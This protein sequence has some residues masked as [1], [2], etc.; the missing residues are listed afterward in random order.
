[1]RPAPFPPFAADAAALYAGMDIPFAPWPAVPM[2]GWYGQQTAV[3]SQQ[4]TLFSC[5]SA[6]L[7][8]G[9]NSLVA[10]LG[11]PL[12]LDVSMFAP[13]VACI[14]SIDA[15][16]LASSSVDL[17]RHRVVSL[18]GVHLVAAVVLDDAAPIGGVN[19]AAAAAIGVP[20][21][22][23]SQSGVGAPQ[24]EV[25]ASLPG[26]VDLQVWLPTS[27]GMVRLCVPRP[28]DLVNS[29][30]P[31]ADL[32]CAVEPQAPAS[33]SETVT[34]FGRYHCF[35][36]SSPLGFDSFVDSDAGAA[37]LLSDPTPY[38]CQLTFRSEW[39]SNPIGVQ[40]LGD[41]NPELRAV[42]QSAPRSISANVLRLCV[43]GQPFES[44][45]VSTMAVEC[46][47]S[48]C[49]DLCDL[50]ASGCARLYFQRSSDAPAPMFG[51][52]SGSV[53]VG[54]FVLEWMDETELRRSGFTLVDPS[55]SVQQVLADSDELPRLFVVFKDPGQGDVQQESQVDRSGDGFGLLSSGGV[56]RR[57]RGRGSGPTNPDSRRDKTL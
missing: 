3:S 22:G 48:I 43:P 44:D 36:L 47:R 56:H 34:S 13:P 38:N 32:V 29:T 25:N 20:G 53:P 9:R 15:P 33:V 18:Y 14:N 19:V 1:M 12:D 49:V 23:A 4:D 28:V 57:S 7:P 17:A 31:L 51:A 52:L 6:W 16:P 27:N 45:V 24:S 41:M 46:S 54:P 40:F 30:D 39:V 50:F 35:A 55:A 10:A 37:V 21:S 42:V 8:L 11:A 2:P 5:V 26:I